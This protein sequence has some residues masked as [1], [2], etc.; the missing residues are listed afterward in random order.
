[1]KQQNFALRQ[2]LVLLVLF[3]L[4]IGACGVPND[5][6]PIAI[7]EESLPV[8][9]TEN[10]PPTPLPES[11]ATNTQIWMVG[12][13]NRLSTVGREITRTPEGVMNSLLLGTET[14]EREAGINSA[15]TRET[16]YTAISLNPATGV[17]VVDLTPGS[18]R[19][20]ASGEQKLAFAQIVFSLIG[21]SDAQG[22]DIRGVA[23]TIDGVPISIPID[24]GASDLG[25]VLTKDDFA[26]LNRQRVSFVDDVDEVPAPLPTPTRTQIGVA[27]IGDGSQLVDLS[28]WMVAPNGNLVRV[29]RTIEESP[30][31][32]MFS[33]LLGPLIPERETGLAS[34]IS[35]DAITLNIDVNEGDGT[36]FVNMSPGSLP[37]V[38][39]NRL[40]AVAQ[41]VFTLTE[42]EDISTV[43][44]SI[45]GIRQLLTD[46]GLEAIDPTL[47]RSDFAELAPDVPG[48]SDPDA[49][50]TPDPELTPGPEAGAEP[51]PADDAAAA[52]AEDTAIDAGPV[53]AT[54][55][56]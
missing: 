14:S 42:L 16:G 1:M 39:L 19:S 46:T 15:I 34:A 26:S 55:T 32:L 7:S 38:G 41:I 52:D 4:I 36:A 9:L 18:L 2:G 44:I 3:A 43:N 5:G 45:G 51:A 53:E 24:A 31:S 29:N 13:D 40:R 47:V 28:V 22:S 21:L 49:T 56:P 37:E 35:T 33:L 23:F 50:V 30:E 12:S 54:P 10:A 17:A 6:S 11:A 48:V 8:D 25:Q 27:P 20:N